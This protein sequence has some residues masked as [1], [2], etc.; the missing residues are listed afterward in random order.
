MTENNNKVA[1]NGAK[2]N[3]D[4]PLLDRMSLEDTFGG[5]RAPENPDPLPTKGFTT[6][7]RPGPTILSGA[8]Q[9]VDPSSLDSLENYLLTRNSDTTIK[10][11]S[12]PRTYAQV[13]SNRYNNF[14]PGDYNNED[15][16]AQGQGWANKMLNGVGK[17]LLLTGTTFLQGTAGLVNGVARSISDGR[18]ASFY[19]NDF[20]R[21]LDE[22]NKK[23]EDIA[24]NYYTDIEKNAS[25]YSPDYLLTSNFLWDGIIKNMGFMAGAALTGGAYG[26]ILKSLPLTAKLFSVGK[27]AEALAATEEALVAANRGA[28][29]YGKI[30]SLSDTFLKQYNLLTPG[31]RAVVAGLST[32]GEAGFEAYQNLNDFRNEKI[33]EYR[34]NNDGLDPTGAELE[35]IN[36]AADAVGNS[37]FLANVALL[38]A[39]N[40]IQFPKILGSSYTAEKGIINELSQSIN[41]IAKVEGKWIAKTSESKLINLFNKIKPYTFSAS[42]GFEEGAQYAIG[43]GAK[44]YYN[45]KYNG[46]PTSFL[47]ALS[48]GITDTVGTDEGM[49]NVVMGGLSGA[50]GMARGNYIE[51]QEQSANTSAAIDA[52][53]KYNISDFTKETID[54]VNRGVVLQE[55]RER[56]LK[57][58]DISSSK[59][60]E[61]DYIINYLT[62]RIKYGRFDL[63]SSD[64]A[65]YKMLA[66]TDEGF[67]Q[68]VQEGKALSTDTKEAYLG[69]LNSFAQT[70]ENVKSLYQSLSLRYAGI[71][72]EKGNS[73]YTPAVMDQMIYAATKVSDYD[74]RIPSLTT[75]L[76]G[77][78]INTT[79]VVQDIIDGKYDTF[80][81]AKSQIESDKLINADQK[82]DLLI[83]LDDIGLMTLKRDMYLKEYDRIKKSPEK[84]HEE[85]EFPVE[86]LS[87]KETIKI[88]TKYGERDIEIGTEYV[89]GKVTEYS[90]KGHEVY[91]QPRLTI[92]GKNEDG[93]ISVRSSNGTIKNISEEELNSYSLTKASKLLTDKKF[94]FFE[95]HQN[96][97]FKHYGIKDINNNPV[98]GR[99]EFNG[100]KDKLTFVYRNDSGKIIKKEVWNTNFKAQEGYNQPMLEVVGQLTTAQIKATNEFTNSLTTVS[101]KL[102]TRNRIIKDLYDNSVKRLN[103]INKQLENSKNS[104]EREEK[105]LLEE[106][107]NAGLTKKGA[108]RKRPTTLQKNLINTLTKLRESVD[109]QNKQLKEEKEELENS[110]PFFKEF[111][112]S[113]QSLPESGKDMID[114][115]KKDID[116]LEDF[117]DITNQSI[118]SSD[119]LLKQIDDM[120]MKA[121]SIFNDYIKRL[122]E[123]N[124]KYP[125]FI[126]D[127][128]A[129]LERFYGEEGAQ[130]IISEKLGFT[131]RV[132]ELES[133]VND[134]SDELKIPSLSKKAEAL[135]SD[136]SELTKG[137]D[138]LINEQIAKAKILESFESY[139]KEVKE[140]EAQAQ[141]MQDNEQLKKDFLGVLTNATQNFFG[142]RPYESA[143]KKKELSVVGSTRPAKDTIPHQERVNYFGNK[144]HYFDNKDS[145]RGRIVTSNTE[146]DIIPGLTD[147]FLLDMPE[148]AQKEEAKKEIIY[149]VVVD[150]NG[151]PVNQNGITISDGESLIDNAIY[152]VF[153]SSSLMGEY[154]GKRETMFREDVSQEDRDFLTQKYS[155]WRKDQL[156]QTS[157]TPSQE[158]N[159][160]FGQPKLVTYRDE[161]G[162]D[163]VDK[164]ART[165]AQ[166]A[167]LIDS[168]TLRTEPLIEV[169]TTNESVD[170]GSTTFQ[171][172]KGRVFLRVPGIGMAK[173]FNRKFNSSE[174]AT[175]FDVMLQITKNTSEDGSVT[176]RSKELFDWLK[177]VSYWG[178]AKY[179]DGRKKPAGYNNIWFESILE[180][181]QVV[182]KLFMSG[183]NKESQRSFDFTPKGLLKS[184][185]DIILLLQE[186]YNNTDASRVNGDKWNTPYS[187][188]IGIDPEGKPITTLWKNY[189]TYLLSDKAP[190]S[191]GKLTVVRKGKELPLA[192]QFRPITESQPINRE[193]IYFTL[194]STPL[195]YEKPKTAIKEVSPVSEEVIKDGKTLNTI[196]HPILGNIVF[197]IN[198]NN[199][200]QL[201]IENSKEAII[202]NAKGEDEQ[203]Q[204]YSANVL[205]TSVQNKFAPKEV[206][207]EEP[208]FVFDNNTLNTIDNPAV[209][210]IVFTATK[211]GKVTLVEGSEQAVITYAEMR[212]FDNDK[213]ASALIKSVETKIGTQLVQQS[214]PVEP[215]VE[216]NFNETTEE[217]NEDFNWH[218]PLSSEDGDDR[219]Y[220]L[221]SIKQTSKVTPED[222]KKVEE[223]IS[224][225]LPNVPLYRVKNIIQA[226]NGRQAWG[227]LQDASIY[228]YEGAETG[229]VYHEVFEA[230][231]KMFAGPIEKQKIIDEFRNRKGSYQDRFTGETIEYKNATPEQLKEE[232]AEE[233]RDFK[234][235]SKPATLI[236]KL[237][238]DIM[239]FIKEF[240]LGRNASSNTKELFD[241]IG[242]GYYAQYNPFEKKLSYANSGIIDIDNIR[243]ENDSDFRA[244]PQ[245][246]PA[247]QVHEIVQEMTYLTLSKL[248]RT[249]Q[250]LFGV[251]KQNKTQLYAELK[252]NILEDTVKR[253]A[254][255]LYK[256]VKL[257]ER[258]LEEITPVV[259]NLQD[260]YEN[261]KKDWEAIVEK[262]LEQL[263]TYSIEFDENDDLLINDEDNSGKSDYVDA[264]KVD[265]FRK[266]N[267]VIKL[268]L[269]TIPSVKVVS[270][271]IEPVYS[272]IGGKVLLPSDQAFI[273]LMNTVHDSTNI[274]VMFDKLR[275]L[276][277]SNPN[278]EVLYRRLT[279]G[280]SINDKLD[281]SKLE[282]H[283]LQ[284][285]TAFWNAMKK[286]NPEVV[287]VFTLPSGEI[288]VGDSVLSGAARQAKREMINNIAESIRSGKSKAFL[289]DK[290]RN[291]YYPSLWVKGISF[292]KSDINQ[293]ISFLNDVGISF[294]PSVIQSKLSVNQFKEFKK[295][296]EGI[297]QSFA[298]VDEIASITSK[299]LDIDG[300]LLRLGT[301]KAITENTDFESTYFNINGERTQSFIGGN[302][303]SSLHDTLSKLT[304]INSLADTSFH[305]LLTD[306]FTKNSSVMLSKMFDITE[307]DSRGSRISGTN[308]LMKPVFIDGMVDQMTGKS[309]ESSKL[310][311]KQ[312]LVQEINL[313]SEGVYLNLVPGDASIEH[314]IRMHYKEDSFVTKEMFN[315]DSYLNIFEKYFISEV[316]LSRDG[317]KVVSGKNS[318]D[319][320]FF[321][322]ILGDKLHNKIMNSSKD[323]SPEEVYINNKKEIDNAVKNFI[324]NEAKETESILRNYGV[325]ST[326][327]EGVNVEG[328]SFAYQRVLDASLLE[329]ELSVVSANY[330]IANIEMHKLIYSDPYQ[331]SDELK[332][333]KNFNSPRQAMVYGSKDM[334][335]SLNNKYNQG[336]EEGELGYT[337]MNR[338]HYRTTVI[339]DVLSTNDLPGYSKPF[340][341]TDGGGLTTLQAHR[342]FLIRTGQWNDAKEEQYR[343]DIAYEKVVKGIELSEREKQFD[344]KKVGNKY[345]GNNPAVKSLYT[346]SKPIVS[347]SKDDGENYNDIVMDKFALMPLSF[348]ILHELNPNSNAI[349]LYN[350]MQEEDV[351]YAVYS[352]GRKVGAGLTSPLYNP[353]GSFNTSS[354]A[355]VNNIPF[356]IMG[357]QTE[358][359]SKDTPLVTQGSQITKLATMDF[360]E[361]GVPI[362][363]NLI[364]KDGNVIT[365]FN[366]R[367]IYWNS[368]VS[369]N[370]KEK[371][372]P[373]YKEI[374]NNELLLI[375]KTE[376][377]YRDLLNKL[378]LSKSINK[379]GQ[380]GFV[381]SDRDKLISTLKEEITKREVNDNILDA[382][383]GFKNGH[384]VLEATPAYQQI[385]N[386]LY[387]IADKN[388]VR[389]KISGGMKVQVSS[390]L[391]EETRSKGVEFKDKKGNIKY[392]YE[393]DVLD[394]YKDED[395][396][397]ICEIMV[398]RWF[399]SNMTDEELLNYL[400][401]TKEGQEILSGVAYRIPTQKQNS[402]DAFRIKQFLPKEF[403]DNVV[404]PSALVKKVGSDF[405]IDK[406][407][408]YLKNTLI[409]G[410]GKLRIVPF[411]GYGQ[412]ARDKFKQLFLDK[413]SVSVQ[414]QVKS[415]NS[416]KDLKELF[417][418]IITGNADQQTAE[419]WLPL[420]ADWFPEAVEDNQL[421]AYE[422]QVKLI[423]TIEDKQKRL[424]ELSDS[425]LTEILAE[426]QSNIWYKQS[427][428]NAYIQSLENLISNPLNFENLI[429]PNSADELKDLAATINELSGKKEIDYS[430]VGNMLSRTFMSGLRQAFVSGKYAIGIAATSQTNN[431]QNQRSP[432]I[433]DTDKL[434]EVNDTDKEILGGKRNSTLFATN[435]NVNFKEYNTLNI[436]GFK[437]PTLSM[438]KDKSGKYISD[439]IGMFIDGYVDIS[440]GPWI[441]E[442]GATPNVAGTWLY[443][444]KI[445]V[446]IDTIAYFINQP[447]IK[448]YLRTIE[449]RGYTWLFNDRILE[450]MLSVYDGGS[451][452]SVEGIPD[453]SE[454]IKMVKYNQ[455]ELRGKMTPVQMAQQQYMLKEFLK[456]AKMA[457]HL[458][459]V[460][461]GSNFD[462]ATI[463][464]PYLLFKKQLQ[465]ETARKTII[466]SVDELLDNSFVGPLKDTM[467]NVRDAFA[468]I[469]LSDKDRVR[470]VM[471][472]V[473][474]PHTKLGD[475]EFIKV[476]QKAVADLFDWAVQ[477]NTD[478][479]SKVSSLLL[480]SDTKIS[481]AQQIIDFRDSILGNNQKGISP[482][483]NHPLFNN[484]ILNSIKIETGIKEGKVN[485]LY[486]AGRDNKVY[487]QNLVIYGFNELKK[488]L[489]AE[490]KDLYSKLVNLA[491][492]QS[493]LTSSP[494]AFTNLLPYEDFKEIYNETLSSLQNM[495]NLADFHNLHVMER[496]NWNNFD[497]V[498]FQ[499]NNMRI[500]QNNMEGTVSMYD[501]NQAFTNKKLKDAMNSK[502]IPMV[503]SLS[504]FTSAGRADFMTYSYEDPIRYSERIVKQKAGDRSY[505]HKVLLQKVYFVNDKGERKP[506]TEI[507]VNK[508]TG[509]EYVKHVYKAINAWGDSFRAKELYDSP[510]SSVIDNDYDKFEREVEDDVI[511]SIL[512]GTTPSISLQ[513]N[514]VQQIDEKPQDISQEEWDKLSEEEKN[515]IKECN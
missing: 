260:L 324:K 368:I 41:D 461:Q 180:D 4:S 139:A 32:T 268:L 338:D 485:N 78:N 248:S 227:M 183:L 426:E 146:N 310:S 16:Y 258:T 267:S 473:L 73:V 174:A 455:Q 389:P 423:K 122:Q 327:A 196:V 192:T 474:R 481:A 176:E 425:D 230:V 167:G 449:N 241:R 286:Q 51:R 344:I 39:T 5:Y 220:R 168:V 182:Q 358:V 492:L 411:F 216:D 387:S 467:Y 35:K 306:V 307:E 7:D 107:T 206:L 439:T 507:Q 261:I 271:K 190:D 3:S 69:R 371:L 56:F 129:Q 421:D 15:A 321:K 100:K 366:E 294:N 395:G 511:S 23:A 265:S 1:Q 415:I 72:D 156:S 406:L 45:K 346:T 297:R 326:T 187:Q 95:K 249:S 444:T 282:E 170:Y 281:F 279:N 204:N 159:V 487:D 98:I 289:Y 59:D 381:V 105:R 121:V 147:N 372:S 394:F 266:A 133:M 340:E 256:S 175:M 71:K 126:E 224:K 264:R 361:A 253:Y 93:T 164:G 396:K 55:E 414:K 226:T 292:G 152:Q 135:V 354:F 75:K 228:L 475:R 364:D 352:T 225:S 97:I 355:E 456:Y 515:K 375:E 119:N 350:K 208:V 110:I 299:T 378:G 318:K 377:G 308:D 360:M 10:G 237:F 353:D 177:S 14:M 443:L 61:T 88:N 500:G 163:I 141:K 191:A 144:F 404:V 43:I 369:E 215:P 462:T 363:Y 337:D 339:D 480:G 477:T 153:P 115:L 465:L 278:Y 370:E 28:A 85:T 158:F 418:S 20:N 203:S 239:N 9:D 221:Q 410:N 169:A 102:K 245:F 407:S 134:M 109:K 440:K 218:T 427:L 284:L 211:E 276:S 37:S 138:T 106:L 70:A 435:P 222:W 157:L 488:G 142:T 233:F 205:Q 382:L 54:S 234:L 30:K 140:E 323:L 52:F 238:K 132:L 506:L 329:T 333:I 112:D 243:V 270:G 431:A 313:N 417:E 413:N 229:T 293:Y 385:R 422:I 151:K 384:V 330:M 345:V 290:K 432:M 231:W 251:Q 217:N 130:Q 288:V 433:I 118:K 201:D 428:E 504:P 8:G 57:E 442:L 92:L 490:G 496:N 441:M 11:G 434:S 280:A 285:V 188:I 31:G 254:T 6:I 21:A 448:D 117:I 393:S 91:R 247:Q 65:D 50:L 160:A 181:G 390:A 185:D 80:N 302:I 419:K 149:M 311:A 513:I 259:N 155:E 172:P 202:K 304:N 476:S 262:H 223:F 401:K 502:Q 123:E 405:D 491:V 235:E 383:D 67:A 408:I 409:D 303:V 436:G 48:T 104:F 482:K 388:V 194:K 165:S 493:G 374:K 49:K 494:I 342:V 438:I 42:E 242:N 219:L 347:G 497:L 505:I 460:T 86:E 124:P 29:S 478:I 128:Q 483:P 348:R 252:R 12:I 489:G 291:R 275:E 380:V 356:S 125:L 471:Q 22:I 331:Y 64:I 53:N 212:G 379:K 244:K 499:G 263:K 392:R 420:I 458:F 509:T 27:A 298:S 464:D 250:S 373:L 166:S 60:T 287:T 214:V 38:S 198:E 316:E 199:E 484:L 127:L 103:S 18:A 312:R 101:E 240:F 334:N 131:E 184:K 207:K 62:P 468:E 173:L 76:N 452:I 162:V 90:A 402:I 325:I 189:Q 232:L 87:T 113:L 459:L 514:P 386:I 210:K 498:P 314:A 36:R 332:R 508:K 74:K 116:V 376:Q 273:T 416:S 66:S 403:G 108:V 412:Q 89:L 320:R 96:T 81:E 13:Q 58:G 99:L 79:Q 424:E 269:A 277:I 457:E 84:Y 193:G 171:T 143:S 469:L 197:T 283:D 137:L 479:N 319:L 430:A 148:G 470:Q 503:I 391:L 450:D 179:P 362:D 301:L 300:A 365:D 83:A 24:P 33:E 451:K 47:E 150:E 351:D 397:R 335:A 495:P 19:D 236:G 466:S 349:K 445:G 510:R 26:A 295:T 454:L 178:L 398:G 341:E 161:K 272:S 25:W 111:L 17:G 463:N 357:L 145:L 453:N 209:G 437:K 309:K 367:F 429:K 305:Y 68:L 447:I 246:I 257:K 63:V 486:I 195:F 136:I 94:N 317:R 512:L 213:A 322:A 34:K 46:E 446:P 77:I 114:Q 40:Y 255:E 2:I 154:N 343:Y 315:N 501:P 274:D 186:M 359:P 44:D 328:L 472:D 336:Y 120:L 82:E 400:N 200:V 296:V 399:K